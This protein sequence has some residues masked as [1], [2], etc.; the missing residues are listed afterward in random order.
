MKNKN[1]SYLLLMP[2][3]KQHVK[4]SRLDHDHVRYSEVTYHSLTM[5][6]SIPMAVSFQKILTLPCLTGASNSLFPA[7]KS[8]ALPAVRIQHGES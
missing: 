6:L 2:S 8:L 7:L 1:Q 5:I 3:G 4:T